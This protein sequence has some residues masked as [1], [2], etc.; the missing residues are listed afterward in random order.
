MIEEDLKKFRLTVSADA[1]RDR[2]LSTS[3]S[4]R[5]WQVVDRWIAGGAA[6]SVALALFVGLATNGTPGS[7]HIEAEAERFA[8]EIGAPELAGPLRRALI[9]PRPPPWRFLDELP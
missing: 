2:I 9:A 4:A 1:L 3:R 7:P 8:A 5:R 6:A